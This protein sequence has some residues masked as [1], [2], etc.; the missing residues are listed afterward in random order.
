MNHPLAKFNFPVYEEPVLT[1]SGKETGHKAIMHG[2]THEVLAVNTNEYKT[3]PYVDSLLPR[4][5]TMLSNGWELAPDNGRFGVR[6]PPT[7]L[8][9]GGRRAFVEMVLPELQFEVGS[10]VITPRMTITGSYDRSMGEHKRMG[11]FVIFC[12]NGAGIFHGRQHKSSIRHVGNVEERINVTMEDV[13]IFLN[14]FDKLR[15][16]WRE[17]EERRPERRIIE[18]AFKESLGERAGEALLNT[19]KTSESGWRLYNKVTQELTYN[20]KGAEDT[21]NLKDRTAFNILSGRQ[22]PAKKEELVT[23]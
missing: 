16:E 21:R 3:I 1:A 15:D 23:A 12:S 19:V 13:N 20:F 8:E 18:A 17:L 22:Q 10:D 4:V 11:V 2:N 9:R 6:R 7:R 14:N 5:N